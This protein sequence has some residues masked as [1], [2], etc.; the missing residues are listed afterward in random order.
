LELETSGLPKESFSTSEVVELTGATA[1]QLQW[2]DERRIVIP[3]RQGRNRLYSAT[4]LVDILVIEQLRRRRISLVQVRRVLRFLRTELHARLADLVRG[5]HEFHLLLDGKRIYLETDSK[6]IVDLLR[7]AKQ[8]MLLVCISD[9]IK[10]LRVELEDLV[11]RL[12]EK[13]P[14]GHHRREE[15]RR[16]TA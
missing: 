4:D 6:Q 11:S 5:A 12:P 1:R 14:A 16:A 9:A 10:P 3:A 13:K 8:P 2:W 15:K 7:N